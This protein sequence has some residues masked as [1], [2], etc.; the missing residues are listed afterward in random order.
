MLNEKVIEAVPQPQNGKGQSQSPSFTSA[1][2]T[3]AERQVKTTITGRLFEM[4][5]AALLAGCVFVLG[6]NFENWFPVVGLVLL[7]MVLSF[8]AFNMAI[9][10]ATGAAKHEEDLRAKREY[11]V[12]VTRLNI[13][14]KVGVPDE[15]IRALSLLLGQPPML[16]DDFFD[17]IATST[18]LGRN[19]T[20]Q[21]RETILKY[22][23]VD[24]N[25]ASKPA[26]TPT[27]KSQ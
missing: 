8:I 18:D 7:L 21:F 4:L 10:Q 13:L 6:L 5:T 2:E 1:S 25:K 12:T 22:T 15:V 14:E 27:L 17:K 16:E 24:K 3:L 11:K 23:E 19:R 20:N 9:R 26:I